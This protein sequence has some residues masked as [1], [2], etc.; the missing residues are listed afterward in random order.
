MAFSLY[1]LE[2]IVGIFILFSPIGLHLPGAQGWA[3]LAWQATLVIAGLLVFANIWMRFF[4]SGP[5][6]W[7]WRS[8]SYNRSQPFR[9]IAAPPFDA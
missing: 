9:R 2:Q 6:E 1:F 4:A 7:V 3:W 5:L 8:L